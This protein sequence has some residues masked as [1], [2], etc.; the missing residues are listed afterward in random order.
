MRHLVGEDEVPAQCQYP[1]QGLRL[2]DSPAESVEASARATIL[3][4]TSREIL[5]HTPISYP[6]A[7]LTVGMDDTV[8]RS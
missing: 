4:E 7:Y 1:K 2:Q 8:A 3:T 5:T 6:G